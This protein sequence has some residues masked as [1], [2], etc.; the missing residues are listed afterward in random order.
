MRFRM[1][2]A[3]RSAL[4]SSRRPVAPRSPAGPHSA[5][6]RL[7]AWLLPAALAFAAP[8]LAESR[9]ETLR[10]HLG[11]GYAKLLNSGSPGGS[12]AI[13]AGVEY[14]LRPSLSAGADVGFALLGNQIFE[15]GSL[16]AELDHS[17]FEA[18]ALL[19]WTPP[20]GPIGRVSVGPGVFH[21]RA[22]LN[23]QGPAEFSDLPI[24]ETTGGMAL[25]LGVLPRR[26]ALVKAGFELGLRTVWLQHGTWT[27]GLGRLTVHY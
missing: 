6:A 14:P 5:S 15:R 25:S 10:G 9:L 24:E 17:L 8:A 26:Q 2:T 7:A 23:S 22:S 12:L 4:T 19:H 3:S 20:R 27:M 18:L 21:A 1:A 13:G 11:L 16:T